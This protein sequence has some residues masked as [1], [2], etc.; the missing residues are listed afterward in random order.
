M[1]VSL[2]AFSLTLACGLAFA[3]L[4]LLRKTI[5]LKVE[6][7]VLLLWMVAGH[8]PFFA[9]WVALDDTRALTSGYWLPGLASIAVQIFANL[10]FLYGVARSP[11]SLTIPILSLTPVFTVG[12]GALVLGEVPSLQQLG[13]IVL[14]VLG[15]VW[16][17]MP[18]EG[19]FALLRS[20]RRF[21]REPGARFMLAAALAW[22]FAAPIDKL[23]IQASSPS[24]HALF[25]LSGMAFSLFLYLAGKRGLSALAVTRNAGLLL[26]LAALAGAVAFGLQLAAFAM[27]FVAFVEA[28]KRVIGQVAALLFGAVFF[29]EPV[30]RPKI[31]AVL[32]MA[33]GIPLLALPGL[34]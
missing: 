13:G 19:G 9:L 24:V 22:S 18:P 10:M 34:F 7:T 8:V 16:L 14:I 30:T 1:S 26:G 15:L 3:L 21:A 27:T 33:A 5:S 2:A 17:Y 20:F 32:L 11:L 6:P 4:D 29:A 23:G 12:F 31:Y 25:Q 28:L